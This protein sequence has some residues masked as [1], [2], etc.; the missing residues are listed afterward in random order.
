MQLLLVL[1]VPILV[2]VIATTQQKH[3]LI[4]VHATYVCVSERSWPTGEELSFWNKVIGV[5]SWFCACLLPG[6][7]RTGF[8]ELERNG[9]N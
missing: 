6:A 1:L 5:L 9:M 4:P 8:C 7:L 2:L 3:N